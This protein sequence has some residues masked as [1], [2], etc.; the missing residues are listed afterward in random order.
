MSPS[1]PLYHVVCRDCTTELLS[2]SESDAEKQARRHADDAS[3]RVA[4][5]YV[6]TQFAPAS[7]D[8]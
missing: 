7:A 6:G 2:H 4:F 1:T 5:G 8:D 3:H